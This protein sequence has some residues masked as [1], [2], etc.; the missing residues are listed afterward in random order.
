VRHRLEK[1]DP[2]AA[3]SPVVEPIVYYV[4][5]GAPPQIQQALVEGASWWADA[6][7][8]AGF[9]DAF[10]VE[11]LPPD[12]HPLDVRYNVVQWV[13]RSTRGWSYGGGITD[14]RT[15]EMI[16]G[17]VS[18]GSL[19]VR[20]DRLIFEGLAGT[21]KTGSGAADDPVEI[22]LARIRQLSAHEV[23][24]TLGFTHNFAAST[25]G[26]ASVMDYPAPLITLGSD[27]RL[28]FSKAYGVGVGEWDKHTVRYAYSQF[29]ATDEAAELE[30]IIQ[31]A[32]DRQLIFVADADARPDGAAHPYGHLW[33]NG[34]DPVAELERLAAVRQ[35]ALANFDQTRIATGQPLSLLHETLVP[36]YLLHRFQIRAAV[37]VLGGLDY[38]YAVRGDERAAAE[39]LDPA[40]QRRALS[41]L[42]DRLEPRELDLRDSLLAVL[43]PRPFGYRGNRELFGGAT[44]PAFDSLGVA[45]TLSD[46][47]VDLLIQPERMA[48]L[49]DH[50]RRDAAQPSLEEVLDTV[51]D[52]IFERQPSSS[53]REAELERVGQAVVVARLLELGR[54]D[55]LAARVR[56]RIDAAIGQLA[57]GLSQSPG[58]ETS[59]AF[60]AALRDSISRY[61]ERRESSPVQRIGTPVAPPGQPIGNGSWSLEEA[62]G[63]SWSD[64]PYAI[65]SSNP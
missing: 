59:R 9:V 19:R 5:S 27:G 35:T 18:L 56:Y 30:E 55:D 37:N 32:A 50:H 12:A 13:H 16:K 21:D 38:S 65:D 39:L 57:E 63:C 29:S 48:R 54:S 53:E 3:R 61:Q 41:S 11:I 45:A 24:H 33:D 4:D 1:T 20:Q 64:W 17:H 49:V 7:D 26:R 47:V 58:D 46:L 6:F 8:A 15:G 31:D 28:D 60:R 2:T 10:R 25:Y 44:S 14:P 36:I 62:S 42:L 22:A 23:G 34:T 43:L 40:W 52:R 51:I